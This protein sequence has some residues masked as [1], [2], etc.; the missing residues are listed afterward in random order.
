LNADPKVIEAELRLGEV[1]VPYRRAGTGAPVLLL[2]EPGPTP[3]GSG[4]T[5]F[6]TL[7]QRY[8]VFQAMTPIPRRRDHAERWLQG[9]VEGLGL[10]MPDVVADPALAPI[11]A[12][13]V[14]QNRGLVG[15]VTFLA[16]T[17]SGTGGA[18]TDEDERRE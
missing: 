15:Q 12:R 14:R 7:S 11:L 3:W 5:T 1:T 2:Q 9:V 17:H 16:G 10:V 8:R 18:R 6:D 4:A 13:L